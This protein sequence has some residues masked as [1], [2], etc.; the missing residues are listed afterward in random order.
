MDLTSVLRVVAQQD[1]EL[2]ANLEQAVG[3]PEKCYAEL[4]LTG[5]RITSCAVKS[6]VGVVL[7][8]NDALQALY[9]MGVFEWTF[10]PALS[11]TPMQ[12]V[13]QASPSQSRALIPNPRQAARS[14]RPTVPVRTRIVQ[15]HEFASWPRHLRFVYNLID[16]NKSVEDIAHILSVHPIKVQEVLAFFQRQG[17]IAFPA[18]SK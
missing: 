10:T 4:Q 14:P 5:G 3:I 12:Q 2:R 16:G 18:D 13:Q 9:M 15:Q 1:G 8:G 7:S 17:L 11:N 6:S